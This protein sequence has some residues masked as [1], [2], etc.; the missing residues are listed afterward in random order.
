MYA[1]EGL[2]QMEDKKSKRCTDQEQVD[3]EITSLGSSH[4][5]M[6]S[7]FDLNEGVISIMEEDGDDE[8]KGKDNNEEGDSTNNNNRS[9]S[10]RDEVNE[11][12]RVRQYVRS[13]IPRL[14]WTPQLHYTFVQAVERLGGQDSKYYYLIRHLI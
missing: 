12:R 1:S 4:D 6:C 14:R 13:K 11:R 2:F 3:E 9:L 10:S 8:E 5:H 7:S